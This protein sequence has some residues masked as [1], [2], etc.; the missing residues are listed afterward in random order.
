MITGKRK[1][2]GKDALSSEIQSF[3]TEDKGKNRFRPLF[4]AFFANIFL[5]L[6]LHKS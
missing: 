1:I 6:T 2:F 5:Y 4:K 3:K